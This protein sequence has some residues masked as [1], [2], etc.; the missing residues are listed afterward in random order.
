MLPAALAP[1][2]IF[3]V[4]LIHKP[5]AFSAPTR[6]FPKQEIHADMPHDP[7]ERKDSEKASHRDRQPP[8]KMPNTT[9]KIQEGPSSVLHSQTAMR[10]ILS[11]SI[12]LLAHTSQDCSENQYQ[13][14]KKNSSTRQ[15]QAVLALLISPYNFIIA[16]FLQQHNPRLAVTDSRRLLVTI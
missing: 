6:G 9:P 14:L 1:F 5:S 11:A 8:G 10:V 2:C 12:Y 13:K 15:D 4:L 16:R 7:H 3:L